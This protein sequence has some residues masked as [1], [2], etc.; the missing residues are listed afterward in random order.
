MEG[1]RWLVDYA[2][3]AYHRVKHPKNEFASGK[4]YIMA[5]G[6]SGVMLNTDCLNLKVLRK[7]ISCFILKNVFTCSY[8]RSKIETRCN[9]RKDTKEL[10]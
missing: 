10:L 1:L 3:K 6:I 5:L 9:D 4:N 8:E 2:A 7:I